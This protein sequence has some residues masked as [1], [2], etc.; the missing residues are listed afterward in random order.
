MK[1]L[2]LSLLL[3]TVVFYNAGCG[4][5]EE[6]ND[7]IVETDA[8]VATWIST[9]TNVAPILNSIFAA[10]G[11]IDT[12]YAIFNTNKSY[13]VKQVNKDKSVINYSGTYS[14]TKSATGNIYTVTLNQSTPSVATAEGIYEITGNTM[15]YEVVQTNP[16]A[17]TPPTP[18]AGFGSTSG[19]AF[20]NT[21]IQ[22]FVKL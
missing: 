3:L 4:D 17:G 14:N 6:S 1:K 5:E 15:K 12:V 2:L 19:G 16:P 7:P 22:N 13:T 10:V 8:I 9:G 21:N 11:G 18:A 20:G